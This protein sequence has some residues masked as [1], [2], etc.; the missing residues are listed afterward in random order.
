MDKQLR[1][2]EEIISTEQT[3]VSELG[4]VI[5]VYITPL[6]DGGVMSREDMQTVFSTWELL[7]G[8]NSKLLE[9]LVSQKDGPEGVKGVPFGTIFKDFSPFFKMYSAYLQNY[10][11]ALQRVVELQSNQRFEAAL[12]TGATDPRCRGKPLTS[13]LIMPVQRIPRYKMLLEELN[14]RTDE[15]WFD[16]ENLEIACKTVGDAAADNNEKI[17]QRENKMKIL[18]IQMHFEGSR[19]PE[20]F[21]NPRRSFIREGPLVKLCRRGP[22]E[23]YFWL[24]SDI[25]VYGQASSDTKYT[26]HREIE[27][28]CC[29]VTADVNQEGRQVEDAHRAFL[30]QSNAKTFI[31]WA[32]HPGE[33]QEWV[34][35]INA[36]IEQMREE[37][38][39]NGELAPLW[40][41]DNAKNHCEVCASA[42]SFLNRRH[43][44]RNCGEL[45]CGQCSTNRIEL[46]HGPNNE[47]KLQRVCDRC[48]ED[49]DQI[50][51]DAHKDAW[52]LSDEPGGR[53]GLQQTPSYNGSQRGQAMD[54][55]AELAAKL[56]F[57]ATSPRTSA[58]PAALRKSSSASVA[59]ASAR[60]QPPTRPHSTTIGALKF[61]RV[62]PPVPRKTYAGA[63]AK[64]LTPG[65]LAGRVKPSAIDF[66]VAGAKGI[67][68]YFSA[69][70]M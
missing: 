59:G 17:R 11:N 29:Q 2:M 31:V 3:F 36:Q 16:K 4:V 24:F 33:K 50:D 28:D 43:H 44:C 6:R 70:W 67:G 26:F 63:K 52:E 51:T 40:Q 7:Y 12:N 66:G 62:P 32:R 58:L 15:T 48:Y 65:S 55:A 25:L 5:D 69:G 14:K 18:D 47:T 9:D 37:K 49:R 22:K 30:I 68:R 42:F 20:L 46:P 54:P 45:V 34:E 8:F 35:E 38:G 39:E 27:L 60:A 23:F 57:E 10:E 21:N 61:G 64:G 1:V 53:P 19:K 13:Y 56:A 41:P